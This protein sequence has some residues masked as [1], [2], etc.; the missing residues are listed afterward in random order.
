MEWMK[1][2]R[3]APRNQP[4]SWAPAA[5]KKSRNW[6]KIAP[7]ARSEAG[8]LLALSRDQIEIAAPYL[9]LHFGPLSKKNGPIRFA[10]KSA[11]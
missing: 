2:S 8:R 6:K 7:E 11:R 3:R 10:S 1:I 5:Q 9:P 4:S